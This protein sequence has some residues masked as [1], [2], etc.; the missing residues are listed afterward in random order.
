MPDFSQQVF[1][2]R[3]KF[4]LS[5][6][7]WE[8]AVAGL[9]CPWLKRFVSLRVVITMRKRFLWWCH[10]ILIWLFF[11]HLAPGHLSYI[12]QESNSIYKYIPTT[13]CTHRFGYTRWCLDCV[14]DLY[15]GYIP[16]PTIF[17]RVLACQKQQ[18]QL[19]HKILQQGINRSAKVF[20]K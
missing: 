18:T 1:V 10:H 15:T 2:K 12:L 8:N 4:S 17:Q 11:F 20:L 14:S 3:R 7:K 16:T 19:L 13:Q 5:Y 9:S 6:F